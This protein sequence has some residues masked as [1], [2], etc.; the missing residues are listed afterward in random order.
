[1]FKELWAME[2]SPE[3]LAMPEGAR[4]D[5]MQWLRQARLH[6]PRKDK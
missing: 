4:L 5:K 3:A 1:M 6:S 2:D